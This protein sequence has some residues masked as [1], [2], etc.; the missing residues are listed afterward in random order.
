[1]L[2]ISNPMTILAFT[3]IFAGIGPLASGYAAAGLLVAGVFCGS[4]L[5]WL[6]LSGGVGL[7]RRRVTSQSMRW[8]NR[9]AGIIL[10]LAGLLSI[11]ATLRQP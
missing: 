3:A 8:I 1:V 6:T 9:A 10:L 7:L 5:W 4:A 2:T 11:A